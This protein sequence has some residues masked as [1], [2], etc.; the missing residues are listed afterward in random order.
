MTRKKILHNM[1]N[2]GRTGKKQSKTLGQNNK[3]TAK[4]G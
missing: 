2:P 3:A 4:P 1:V